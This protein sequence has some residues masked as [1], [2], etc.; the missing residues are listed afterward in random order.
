VLAR[1]FALVR[2]A[3]GTMVRSAA[4]VPLGQELEIE[5]ADGRVMAEAKG[6]AAATRTK[7]TEASSAAPKPTLSPQKKQ[8][9]D[10]GSLF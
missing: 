8:P 10:Q 2:N 4:A 5:F 1:G 9:K 6:Q 3:E 7:P